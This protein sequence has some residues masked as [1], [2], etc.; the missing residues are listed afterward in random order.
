MDLRPLL[1]ASP[2][3]DLIR[4][5]LGLEGDWS[6][7][8]RVAWTRAHGTQRLDGRQLEHSSFKPSL[9]L[10]F[11]DGW[12]GMHCYRRVA[13]KYVLD[14]ELLKSVIELVE[15]TVRDELRPG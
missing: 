12:I 8:V 10:Y 1:S 13:D 11:V 2:L 7:S 4:I 6:A 14:V 9:E 5:D 15:A 3:E